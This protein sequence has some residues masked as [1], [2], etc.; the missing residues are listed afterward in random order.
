MDTPTRFDA[1]ETLSAWL[2]GRLPDQANAFRTSAT[3]EIRNGVSMQR[4]AQL[5]ALASRHARA[6]VPLA[7]TA[8]ELEPLAA[9]VPGWHPVQWSLLETLRVALLLAAPDIES[10]AFAAA[11]EYCFQFADH[12]ESCALYRALPLLPHGERF[13]WRARE[14]CRT[15][16]RPLF[17]AVALD[18]PYPAQHFDDVA[19]RQL[20]I[21]A[22]FI[23][24]P[25]WR[26]DGLDRR[27]SPELARMALDFADERRSAG[28]AVSPQT[29]LCLGPYAGERGLRALR[30]ELAEGDE[31][32]KQGALLALARA[33]ELMPERDW[34]RT[35][36]G[37][38]SGITSSAHSATASSATSAFGNHTPFIER[39]REDGFTQRAFRFLSPSHEDRP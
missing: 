16:M 28:R 14:G 30:K 33:G 4:L 29:W 31:R 38:T 35:T 5:L 9:A 1:A 37:I 8:N 13:V 26:I 25:L 22:V 32:G 36:L 19:W 7:L 17:E 21:K 10:D 2:G 24:A 12:G 15:N 20:V 34:L 3:N 6:G 39:A 23:D 11:F 27:L 18:S